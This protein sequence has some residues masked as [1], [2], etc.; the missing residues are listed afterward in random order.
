VLSITGIG[1]TVMIKFKVDVPPGLIALMVASNVPEVV[2]VPLMNPV[3]ELSVRPGG[4]SP[5]G[6]KPAGIW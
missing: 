3:E 5:V 4:N 1:S 2:G 6:V